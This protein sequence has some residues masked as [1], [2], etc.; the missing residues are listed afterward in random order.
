MPVGAG[1]YGSM[2]GDGWYTF[3][4]D[5]WYT[6]VGVGWYTLCDGISVTLCDGRFGPNSPLVGEG[7]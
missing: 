6:F 7:A 3:V 1:R 2:V 5:G 4:G